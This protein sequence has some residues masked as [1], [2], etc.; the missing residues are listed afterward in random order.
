M[1]RPL[2]FIEIVIAIVALNVISYQL[3]TRFDFTEGNIYTLSKSSKNIAKDLSTEVNVKLFLSDNLPAQFVKTK[4]DIEDYLAEYVALS[5]G[6]IKVETINPLK[7]DEDEKMAQVL[8]IPP[9]QLQVIEKDQRQTVKAYM[10]LAVLKNDPEK[11]A[12]ENNPF[13]QLEKYEVIPM[14]TDLRSFEYDF[15]AA[16]KKVSSLEE[17]TIGFLSGHGEHEVISNQPSFTKPE[18]RQ[19]YA[20]RD[21]LEKNYTV[22]DVTL[23]DAANLEEID[24]L[25][26]AGPTEAI[27][28]SEVGQIEEFVTSGGNAI[29]LIDQIEIKEG[30]MAAKM[31]ETFENLLA[32]WGVVVEK[33]L[34]KDAT[35]TN[36]S[37]SQGFFS[38][39][40]PYPY[41]VR[42]RNLN[43]ENS[44]TSQLESFILPW[45]S[46]LR[47]EE[48]EDVTVEVLAETSGR[49]GLEQAEVMV[50]KQLEEGQEL[51][52]GE[53]MEMVL[54]DNPMNLDPQQ[55]SF[56][57]PRNTKE[58]LPLVVQAQKKDDAG[59]VIILGDSDFITRGYAG[60]FT[61]NVLFFLNA[62]DVFTLGEDLVSIR[63]KGVT[64]RPIAELSEAQKNS[65]RWLNILLIPILVIAFGLTRR[66]MRNAR[67]RS[68]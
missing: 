40:L 67:K 45:V 21:V 7:D 44:I 12:D 4:Q 20:L 66:M 41:W 16:L 33:A 36:A 61:G 42:V 59:K 57:I 32:P 68:V 2:K 63:S 28:D 17:K 62:I 64:D 46:P 11:E 52:E 30:I 60:Q 14:L 27:P 35:N 9:L 6:K 49:Y 15:S 55:Q 65:M 53:E 8:G 24:T 58:P 31:T 25:V 3:F 1:K 43:K 48:K 26:V 47:V 10:G 50:P 13:A 29:F 19:D 39:S 38:F 34:V 37:F 51:A 5:G 23:G 56:N 22:M 18:P 54:Q